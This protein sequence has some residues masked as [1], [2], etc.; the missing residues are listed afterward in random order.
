MSLLNVD[1]FAMLQRAN[2]TRAQIATQQRKFYNLFRIC[3][4]STME[5][6]E[7]RKLREQNEAL[8]EMLRKAESAYRK[9]YAGVTG[10]LHAAMFDVRAVI[11]SV[12]GGES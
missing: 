7:L 4:L 5:V 9:D 2:F 3:P 11:A 1:E 10:H 6:A 8:L 12:N